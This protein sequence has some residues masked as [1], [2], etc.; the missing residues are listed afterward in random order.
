VGSLDWS[1]EL[2]ASA[3]LRRETFSVPGIE[4]ERSSPLASAYSSTQA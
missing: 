2:F 1:G 4:D 3:L